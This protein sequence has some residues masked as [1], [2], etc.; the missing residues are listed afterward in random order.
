[1][2]SINPYICFL[3]SCEEAFNYYKTVFGGEF[4]H[5]FRY[6]EM[7]P[8]SDCP[9][10]DKGDENLIMHIALPIGKH[11]VLMGCDLSSSCNVDKTKSHSDM[12]Q[13][14]V[15]PDSEE[16]AKKIFCQLSEGGKVVMPLEKQFWNALFGMF[17]DRFGTHWMVNYEYPQEK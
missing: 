6:S 1:M 9:P 15:H 10:L 12:F 16:E 4:T 14:S 3:G 7:P 13:V 8:N 17:V 11:S 5:V 2:T